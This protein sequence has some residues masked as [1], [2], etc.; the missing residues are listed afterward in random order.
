MRENRPYGV[1]ITQESR[2]VMSIHPLK[3]KVPLDLEL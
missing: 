1:F 3:V 2:S